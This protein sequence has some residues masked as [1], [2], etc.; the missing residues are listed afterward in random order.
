MAKKKNK[1]LAIILAVIFISSMFSPALF[2]LA[3]SPADLIDRV[4]I[5]DVSIIEHTDGYYSPEIGGEMAEAFFL[6]S[7]FNINYRYTVYFKDNTS[8]TGYRYSNIQVGDNW[9][10]L[11]FDTV[12]SQQEHHWEANNTYT[13]S[14]TFAGVD[15]SFNVSIIENP[16]ERIEVQNTVVMENCDGYL[17]TDYEGEEFWCFTPYPT[18]TVYFKNGNQTTYYGGDGLEIG[19]RWYSLE[20]DTIDQYTNHWAVGETHTVNCS[21]LGAQASFEVTVIEQPAFDY[22]FNGRGVIIQGY[23]KPETDVVIPDE[24]NEMPVVGIYWLRSHDITSV[25]I[26]ASVTYLSDGA[27]RCYTLEN[28]FVSE[29]NPNYADIDGVLTDKAKTKILAYPLAK[30]DTYDVPAG[31]TDVSIFDNWPYEDVT[32][33]IDESQYTNVGGVLYTKDMKTVVKC[34]K[35]VSGSYVMPESVTE[36]SPK[37]FL[38]CKNVTSIKVSSGVTAITYAAFAGCS[39]M[40]GVDLPSGLKTIEASAFQNSGL[41]SVSIPDSVTEVC[42]F[43]FSGCNDLES[44]TMP[45]NITSIQVGTFRYCGSLKNINVPG[46]V[47]DI[48]R[49]AFAYCDSL[50]GINLPAGLERIGDMAFYESGLTGINI[51]DSVQYAGSSAFAYCRDLKSVKIGSG[52][53]SI[54]SGTFS[55]CGG[56]ESI[57]IPPNVSTIS[58]NAFSGCY[59]LKTVNFLNSKVKIYDYAFCG[60]DLTNTKLPKNIER[61]EQGVFEDTNITKAEIP[62]TVTDIV[63][64]AFSYSKVQTIDM[65]QSVKHISGYSF[66]ETPWLNAQPDGPVYIN[67]IFYLYKGTIPAN[68]DVSVKSG[69]TVIADDAFAMIWHRIG[70]GPKTVALP[71]GLEYIGREAFYNCTGLKAIKLPASVIEI[72]YGAFYSCTGLTD[73]YYTGTEQQKANISIDWGNNYLTNANWHYNYDPDKP[74][75]MHEKTQIRNAK[76]ATCIMSGYTGDTYCVDCGEKIAYGDV[77]G[78]TGHIRGNWKTAVKATL[79]EQGLKQ[80]VCKDCGRVLDEETVPAL[81]VT[82]DI[83]NAVKNE[84]ENVSVAAS[85][86][87]N[88]PNTV[89]VIAEKT[90]ITEDGVTYEI[91]LKNGGEEIQPQAPVL[92]K[93]PIPDG[94]DRENLNIYRR[95][96]DGSKTRMNYIIDG[97][98]AY[99]ETDHFSIYEMIEKICGDINSDDTTDNK[100]LIRLFQYLSEWGVDV[101]DIALDVNG[102][103]NSDNKDL[104]RLFQYLS[105]WDVEIF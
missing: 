101:N 69:T 3:S 88:L 20:F 44:V 37:A 12:A 54:S 87:S 11:E 6:Y 81:G 7:D 46:S 31:V 95:E 18:Y 16:V 84:A 55:G 43:A 51:P 53:T 86:G 78:P 90:E 49:V 104:I 105:E 36:I 30:G 57:T 71:E 5:D 32:V 10:S 68:A 58:F 24:I 41:T 9:Y 34:K 99:F 100:D 13:V 23:N 103:G 4:E 1:L 75:C 85:D 82:Y 15:C 83:E 92:V 80:E 2:V 91:T 52:L 28:I 66:D 14:C 98:F 47:K 22:F 56:L 62:G 42:Y 97:D 96:A 64:R 60:C 72:G 40:T 59:Y 73:V 74:L 25:T 17:T 61:I 8:K 48:G 89:E 38:N 21:L 27:F 94:I 93:L 79:T 102:D 77:I 76:K 39:G 19:D 65:P 45:Q 50:E 67:H 33:N 70:T 29:D 63:Y 35:E 26:P